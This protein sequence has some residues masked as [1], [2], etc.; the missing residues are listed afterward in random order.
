ML[1]HLDNRLRLL[2]WLNEGGALV[3][4]FSASDLKPMKEWIRRYSNRRDMDFAD[5]SLVW[6]ANA[7]ATEEILTLDY[8]DFE[9]YRLP[10]GKLFHIL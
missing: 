9:R 10:S 6:L 7:V 2:S 8:N 1:S 3:Y 4:N 5:A